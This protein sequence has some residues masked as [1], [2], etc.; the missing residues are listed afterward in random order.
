MIDG[1]RAWA[2]GALDRIEEVALS[3]VGWFGQNQEAPGTYR[4]GHDPSL[5][6]RK[7]AL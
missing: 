7:P 6:V 5:Y 1:E 3:A 2:M 4:M